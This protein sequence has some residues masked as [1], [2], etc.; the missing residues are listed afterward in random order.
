LP[1]KIAKRACLWARRKPLRFATYGQYI[2]F[3]HGFDD[4]DR[5]AQ[6][7]F[8]LSEKKTMMRYVLPTL[9]GGRA[10]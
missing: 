8:T 7:R 5:E 6:L 3:V 2:A 10:N 1:K 9:G 4:S